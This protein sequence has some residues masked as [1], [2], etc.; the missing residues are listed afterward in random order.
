LTR[1]IVGDR[2]RISN[3][4]FWACGATGTIAIV[5]QAVTTISG[6]RKEGLTREETSALGTHTVYW[7]IFDEPQYDAEE[8]GPYQAGFIWEESLTL[9]TRTVN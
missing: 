1:F 9:L 5:P 7:V 4:F 8:D 2:V 6:E 3:D